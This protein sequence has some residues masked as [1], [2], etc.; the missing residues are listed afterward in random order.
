MQEVYYINIPTNAKDPKDWADIMT[1]HNKK[2]E[3]MPKEILKDKKLLETLVEYQ[4]TLI[5]RL[6][7]EGYENHFSLILIPYP[8]ADETLLKESVM[9]LL[10]ISDRLFYI[11]GNIIVLLP[12]ADWNGA[13]KVHETIAQA[14]DIWPIEDCIV[15]YPTDGK[16]AHQLIE[17]LYKRL[18]EI[19]AE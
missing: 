2:R 11:D 4:V 10:R 19:N 9:P 1:I 17:N 3:T 5:E 13:L 14:L 15:E 7:A 8:D 6:R 12:G 18:E 16:H